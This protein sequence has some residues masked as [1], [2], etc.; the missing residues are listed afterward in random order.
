MLRLIITCQILLQFP[1]AVLFAN[2]AATDPQP[3]LLQ[4]VAFGDS[5]TAG[6]QLDKEQAWPAIL[7]DHLNAKDPVAHVINAGI[8]GLS[9][10]SGRQY[11]PVLLRQPIDIFILALGAND[12]LRG[13]SPD[14]TE[15]NLQSIIDQICAAHPQ[16]TLILVGMLAP[17]NLGEAYTTRFKAI[18][19]KLAADNE[20]QLIPFLLEGVAGDPSL[21][22]ADGIHP[23]AAGQKILAATIWNEL[24]KHLPTHKADPLPEGQQEKLPI[25]KE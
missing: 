3:S 12:A 11:L 5:L 6:Y 16:A 13:V 15:A 22:L 17:P 14:I 23:N 10:A 20:L 4:I 18:Y 8:S 1:S 25:N 19:T 21:N 24:H 7:S 2:S 9:S